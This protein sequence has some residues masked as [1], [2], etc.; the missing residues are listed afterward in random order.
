LANDSRIGKFAIGD[1]PT[2]ADLCIML[3]V[4]N[5]QRFNIDLAPFAAIQRLFDNAMQLDAFRHAMPAAQ[6]DAK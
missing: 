3:Q 4:F 6:P 2:L 5:A 1:T